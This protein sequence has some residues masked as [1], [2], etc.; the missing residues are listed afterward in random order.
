MLKLCLKLSAIP[1]VFSSFPYYLTKTN[2][3]TCTTS[4]SASARCALENAAKAKQN[5]EFFMSEILTNFASF[6]QKIKSEILPSGFASVFGKDS[7]AFH[8]FKYSDIG[9]YQDASK[10]L[11]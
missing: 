3:F 6:Q 5:E 4:A 10:L 8:Y 9:N 1:H 2:I 7:Q 11:L